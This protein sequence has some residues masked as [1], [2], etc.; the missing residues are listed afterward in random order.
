[1]SISFFSDD[2]PLSAVNSLFDSLRFNGHVDHATIS[3]EESHQNNG[4][5]FHSAHPKRR[6]TV[7]PASAKRDLEAKRLERE[8][9]KQY[10]REQELNA[11]KQERDIKFLDELYAEI[12]NLEMNGKPSGAVLGRSCISGQKHRTD[13]HKKC[14]TPAATRMS[15]STAGRT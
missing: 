1:V 6:R 4:N 5:Y 8:K 10:R 14:C 12:A 7:S 13:A 9:R 15:R 3:E 11:R 2:V